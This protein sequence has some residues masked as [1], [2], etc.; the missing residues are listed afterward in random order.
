VELDVAG[1]VAGTQWR[2]MFE[3]RMKNVLK[4]A[5]DAR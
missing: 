1:M 3:E 5:E 2:G 4:E